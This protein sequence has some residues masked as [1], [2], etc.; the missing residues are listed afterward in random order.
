MQAP[1]KPPNTIS[2]QPKGQLS[3]TSK[4]RSS[5][6]FYQHINFV[7]LN[8]NGVLIF[9]CQIFTQHMDKEYVLGATIFKSSNYMAQK[10]LY[11]INF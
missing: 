1:R 10:F 2:H 9:S 6:F 5:I 3:L 8:T 4:G 11:D 7:Q